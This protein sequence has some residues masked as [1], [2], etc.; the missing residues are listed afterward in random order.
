VAPRIRVRNGV[1]AP[2]DVLGLGL[3]NPAQE[4]PGMAR[5]LNVEAWSGAAGHD[6][7]PPDSRHSHANDGGHGPGHDL[8]DDHRHTGSHKV[9]HSQHQELAYW[10]EEHASHAMDAGHLHG[11][12]PN[13]H[14]ERI[15]TFCLVIDA[16]LDDSMLDAWLDLLLS[17][18]G[19]DMLRIK[20]ILNLRGRPVPVVIHGVQHIFYPPVELPAWPD[21]DRRSKIVFITRD[22]ARQTIE[23]SLHSFL[24]VWQ[25]H[26]SSSAA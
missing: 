12:D 8:P 19:P 15:R 6:R 18:A 17:L 16:P 1:V 22:I 10:R 25:G 26:R 13:R 4:I 7:W 2:A 23:D 20:G 9:A 5:W 21:A 3:F 11:H 24:D 14:D